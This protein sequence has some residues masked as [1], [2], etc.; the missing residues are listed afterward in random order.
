MERGH[1]TH[2][3]S[4]QTCNNNTRRWYLQPKI[5]F[6]STNNNKS[7][8]TKLV[9]YFI[10]LWRGK[11]G[12]DSEFP[13]SWEI[14]AGDASRGPAYPLWNLGITSSH[15][16]R[17]LFT[18]VETPTSTT[19]PLREKKV[20]PIMAEP[21]LDVCQGIVTLTGYIRITVR[22]Y[23][24]SSQSSY[25]HQLAGR[26]ACTSFQECFLYDPSAIGFIETGLCFC[27]SPWRQNILI[28][29]SSLFN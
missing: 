6:V 16:K 29:V 23:H 4:E 27:F 20:Q 26:S 5:V 28:S 13:V 19:E 21:V 8:K 15:S 2:L 17:Q 25:F 12:T 3:L 7:F 14:K 10:L 22:G 18:P 9:E 11:R 24:T 1:P